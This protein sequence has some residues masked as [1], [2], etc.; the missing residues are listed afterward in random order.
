MWPRSL[1]RFLFLDSSFFGFISTIRREMPS[2]ACPLLR[3]RIEAAASSN[4]LFANVALDHATDMMKS[5]AA[6]LDGQLMDDF[7]AILKGNCMYYH[8]FVADRKDFFLFEKL[9][10]E[11]E[12]QSAA[13]AL[14]AE[15]KGGQEAGGMV[16]W[17]KHMKYENP[18]G[19]S[20]VFQAIV[21]M[22]CEY[23]DT[24]MFAC[25]LNYY[26]SGEH[27]KPFH[28]DSHAYG[29]KG[30]KEDIT[31]GV[32]L[33]GTRAL[34]FLHEPSKKQFSFPQL[35]GDVFAFT[36]EVNSRFQHGVPRGP[37]DCGERFSIIVWGK[38][39][40]VNERNGGAA[41]I[42]DQIGRGKKLDTMEDAIQCAHEL[43]SVDR[44]GGTRPSNIDGSSSAGGLVGAAKP[45]KKNRLQ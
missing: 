33:G 24:E 31:I 41:R 12:A 40:S 23:F 4:G 15:G 9:K 36:S 16:D 17:S 35:N 14:K 18:I 5:E 22:V 28:Y 2:W 38:R 34:A 43:V 37:K 6:R 25:R 27:W 44:R 8:D 45:K 42:D 19:V 32:S 29:G 39:R 1:I 13:D 26:G 21:E 7:N 20:S 11:L 30:Q 10:V 3:E